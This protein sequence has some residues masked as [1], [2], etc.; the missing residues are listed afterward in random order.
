MSNLSSALQGT[1]GPLGNASLPPP[2]V[3][4]QATAGTAPSTAT[5]D[6]SAAPASGGLTERL[7]A[8]KTTFREFPSIPTFNSVATVKFN[9]EWG[10]LQNT[11]DTAE[12]YSTIELPDCNIHAE[13]VVR[14]PVLLRGTGES[15]ITGNGTGHVMLVGGDLVILE[16]LT[17][18][19][20]DT[21]RGGAVEVVKGTTRLVGCKITS[22]SLSCVG[23]HEEAVVEVERCHLS[24]SYNPALCASEKSLIRCTNTE[25]SNCKTYGALATKEATIYLRV[26]QLFGHQACAIAAME[27]GNV[28]VSQ[29]EIYKNG[30]AGVEITSNGSIVL[31]ECTIRDHDSVGIIVQ[32]QV[33]AE[34]TRCKFMRCSLGAIKMTEGGVLRSTQN[35]YA[36]ATENVMI[37]SHANSYVYSYKDFFQGGCL[38]AFAAFEGGRF[39]GEGLTIQNVPG[40]GALSY[41]QGHLSLRHSVFTGVGK[42]SLQ[43]RDNATLQLDTVESRNSGSNPLMITEGVKGFA[44]NCKFDTGGN[45]GCEMVGIDDFE[46]TNCEFNS[47]KMAGFACQKVVLKFTNCKFN[48]NGQIGVD[49]NGEGSKTTFTGCEFNKNGEAGFSCVNGAEA[50]LDSSVIGDS[51]KIGLSAS[52]CNMQVTNVEFRGNANAAI[53]ATDH[54]VIKFVK[55]N[56]H[57]NMGFGAQAHQSG[58]KVRFEDCTMVDQTQGL[59]IMAVESAKVKCVKCTIKNSLHPHCE[60]ANSARCTLQECDVGTATGG[61]CLQ[62]HDGGVL[63]LKNT[64]VHGA[65]K[66]GVMVGTKGVMKGFD[67]KI[68]DCGTCAFCAQAESTS[69]LVKCEIVKGGD[70]AVQIQGGDVTLTD[71]VVKEHTSYGVIVAGGGKFHDNNTLFSMNGQKNVVE[72]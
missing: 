25:V 27:S 12:P 38:A 20:V 26:C 2:V 48:Q 57:D 16:N 24:G 60:I 17:I 14:K 39:D 50:T 58:T 71:C 62:V 49:V 34:V 53:S 45:V 28:N 13:L 47:N 15:K 70:V 21:Q 68:T 18:H 42:I 5:V 29:C 23:A 69:E 33:G 43:V 41:T 3:P 31:S 4:L 6:P 44:R 36:D 52:H 32:G 35:S 64:H 56:I 59:A 63:Q 61:I 37:M 51:G 54:A 1:S 67:S 22:E 30:N 55:C 65:P 19:Q 8:V 40:C 7:A 46:F 66:F 9:P 72:I 10:N 11:L